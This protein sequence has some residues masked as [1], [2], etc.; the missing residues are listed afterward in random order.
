MTSFNAHQLKLAHQA[1]EWVLSD[2]YQPAT[3][4][5]PCIPVGTRVI[6]SRRCGGPAAGVVIGGY[7]TYVTVQLDAGAVWNCR[8]AT[9][10]Q[11]LGA[12]Q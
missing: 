11:T 5:T 6:V 12:Q 4:N 9:V 3:P 10:T 7:A 1:H 8:P 2:D